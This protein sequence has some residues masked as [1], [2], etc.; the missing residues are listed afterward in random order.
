MRK[1][2]Y[3]G[4]TREVCDCFIF[5][6][7][8]IRKRATSSEVLSLNFDIAIDFGDSIIFKSIRPVAYITSGANVFGAVDRWYD[9]KVDRIEIGRNVKEVHISNVRETIWI[10]SCSKQSYHETL[11]EQ[12][13]KKDFSSSNLT[14][15]LKKNNGNSIIPCPKIA[16]CIGMTTTFNYPTCNLTHSH[17]AEDIEDIDLDIEDLLYCSYQALQVVKEE[18]KKA[19]GKSL[20]SCATKEFL[21]DQVKDIVPYQ[22]KDHFPWYISDSSDM[23]NNGFGL[24]Y[25]MS[26][27]RSANNLWLGRLTKAVRTEY[28]VMSEIGLIGTVGGTL[29]LFVGWSFTGCGT[30]MMRM[31]KNCLSGMRMVRRRI[32][33][34]RRQLGLP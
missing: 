29:G 2:L 16:I 32:H 20:K 27:P 6:S 13:F 12:Y 26:L 17:T 8:E 31:I 14:V 24:L 19:R 22:R 33:P 25:Q 4:W 28:Y 7:E 1:R 18:M 30:V 11:T 10:G 21:V 9:G 34:K 23:G 5:K 3:D 15:N